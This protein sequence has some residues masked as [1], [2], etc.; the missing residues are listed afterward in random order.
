MIKLVGFIF[1]LSQLTDSL[2]YFLFIFRSPVA[3]LFEH[4]ALQFRGVIE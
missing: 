2:T 4:T 3:S 1:Y